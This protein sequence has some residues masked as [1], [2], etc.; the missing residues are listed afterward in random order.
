MNKKTYWRKICLLHALLSSLDSFWFLFFNKIWSRLKF[1]FGKAKIHKKYQWHLRVM[2]TNVIRRNKTF[3][4]CY[5]KI[6]SSTQ[7]LLTKSLQLHLWLKTLSDTGDSLNTF[8][9]NVS[10][11]KTSPY[12]LFIL[13]C[14]M[15]SVQVSEMLLIFSPDFV[16]NSVLVT[17]HPRI[18][19]LTDALA[20]RM[21]ALLSW[22]SGIIRI[23]YRSLWIIGSLYCCGAQDV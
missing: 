10:L 3:W 16:I 9:I 21:L 19:E 18:H 22:T 14:T 12:Q 7:L 1:C 2:N 11:Q 8:W 15:F 23:R 17:S 6:I 20:D 13:K 4:H 5:S